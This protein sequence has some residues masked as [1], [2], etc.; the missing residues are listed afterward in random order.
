MS[1]HA[2]LFL[3]GCRS[4]SRD[5]MKSLIYLIFSKWRVIPFSCLTQNEK[6]ED[7]T[8]TERGRHLT[9]RGTCTIIT[10]YRI[11][12]GHFS[13][14]QWTTIPLAWSV[15]QLVS[16]PIEYAP[17]F[18]HCFSP[19]GGYHCSKTSLA[20]LPV[21]QLPAFQPALSGWLKL[22]VGSSLQSASMSALVLTNI[23]SAGVPHR[24]KPQGNLG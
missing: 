7:F 15:L 10:S 19:S 22:Q 14:Q 3:S 23:L 18:Q 24:L 11:I 1:L 17:F 2:G 21:L 16:H 13:T 6:T 20:P 8:S 5:S 12:I 4:A 9:Q